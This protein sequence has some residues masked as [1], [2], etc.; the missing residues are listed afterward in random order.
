MAV[1]ILDDKPNYVTDDLH[2]LRGALS[3][4]PANGGIPPKADGCLLVATWNVRHFGGLTR[5]WRSVTGDSPTRDV[6]S[7]LFIAEILN[8]FDVVALQEIKGETTAL[9]EAMTWLNRNEPDR[10]RIVATDVTRGSTGNTERLGYLYDSQSVTATGLAAEL[11]V[12]PNHSDLGI[13]GDALED[14]FA[15]TPYAVSF[16]HGDH[17]FILTTLHVIYGGDDDKESRRRELRAIA[18]WL[19][20]WARDDHI[21][22]QSDVLALGDFNIDRRDDPRWRAFVSTHLTVPAELQRPEVVRSVFHSPGTPATTEK[23]Y[24]QIAWFTG[25]AGGP[26]I[27]MRY[28]GAGGHFDFVPHVLGDLTKSSMSYRLSDHYPLWV[29][30]SCP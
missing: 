20:D 21:W 5:K 29:Q 17:N 9:R 19:D 10:W 3:R 15:R 22:D 11:V 25:A 26:S 12:P 18:G 16:R 7:C 8:R 13:T 14:Q 24:D 28:T 23:F 4:A 6:R 2:R 1:D 27:R 30:F